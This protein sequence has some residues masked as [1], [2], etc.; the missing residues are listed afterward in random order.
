VCRFS[1]S[2]EASEL[3]KAPKTAPKRTIF[4]FIPSSFRP[5][6]A[7]SVKTADMAVI[8]LSESRCRRKRAEGG[9][10]EFLI[11]SEGVLLQSWDISIADAVWKLGFVYL[12]SIGDVVAVSLC[13]RLAPPIAKGAAYYEIADLDPKRVFLRTAGPDATLEIFV[14]FGPAIRRIHALCVA[15]GTEKPSPVYPV[16]EWDN[17][18]LRAHSES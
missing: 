8:S 6:Y 9:D 15:V 17:P 5:A 3:A 12:R 7:H 10:L 16:D 2:G 18:E 14:G 1:G 13:P 4:V 11:D